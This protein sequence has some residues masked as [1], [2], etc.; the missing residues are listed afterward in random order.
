MEDGSKEAK[1]ASYTVTKRQVFGGDGITPDE[2][3]RA[4]EATE[5]RIA[6][7]DAIFYF[8]RQNHALTEVSDDELVEFSRFA[9]EW[10]LNEMD[11]MKDQEFARVRLQY[12]LTLAQQGI[13]SAKQQMLSSDPQVIAAIRSMARA[14]AFARSPQRQTLSS[15]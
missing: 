13:S 1:V 14:A 10:G 9:N 8:A 15:K 11:V 5:N 2:F 7:L 12:T 4:E 3:V 6:M